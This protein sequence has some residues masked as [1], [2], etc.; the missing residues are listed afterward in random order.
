[1]FDDESQLVRPDGLSVRRRR[2]D[3]AG[4]PAIS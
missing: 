2:H 3:K 1:M 4:R